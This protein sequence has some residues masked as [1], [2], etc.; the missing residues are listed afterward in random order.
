MEFDDDFTAIQ[1][2]EERGF[3]MLNDG[4]WQWRRLIPPN[5]DEAAAINY[6]FDEWDFGG[7]VGE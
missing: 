4:K 5:V 1:F 7:Y 3:K 6:L 2:L